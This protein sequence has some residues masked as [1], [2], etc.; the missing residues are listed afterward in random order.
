M[1]LKSYGNP[2]LFRTVSNRSVSRNRFA[3]L[4]AV[5]WCDNH[6]LVCT[7][8]HQPAFNCHPPKCIFV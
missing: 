3:N 1:T 4:P 5:C 7:P 2:Q 6:V 8:A